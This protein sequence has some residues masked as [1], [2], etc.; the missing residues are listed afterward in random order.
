MAKK[1]ANRITGNETGSLA[2]HVNIND[3]M[4]GNLLKNVSLLQIFDIPL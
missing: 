2:D 3:K 4:Y 1:R